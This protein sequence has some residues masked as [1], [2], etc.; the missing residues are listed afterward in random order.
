MLYNLFF[1]KV[2]MPVLSVN[3]KI[4]FIKTKWKMFTSLEQKSIESLFFQGS[5]VTLLRLVGC[6]STDAL[7][8]TDNHDAMTDY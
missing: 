7:H 2:K 4:L 5:T 1:D 8:E 3:S 6:L